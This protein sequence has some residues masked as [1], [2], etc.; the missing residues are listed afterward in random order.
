MKKK[1]RNFLILIP[2]IVLTIVLFIWDIT[3]HSVNWESVPSVWILAVV[4]FFYC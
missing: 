3:G 2:S 1:K 4:L